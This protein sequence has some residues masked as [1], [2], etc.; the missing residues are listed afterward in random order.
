[1]KNLCKTC[2]VRE[3]C[4][5]AYGKTCE[6]SCESYRPGAIEVTPA[7]VLAVRAEFDAKLREVDSIMDRCNAL[8]LEV[9]RLT[10]PEPPTFMGFVRWILRGFK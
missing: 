1:M 8:A 10:I 6:T 9:A 7:N 3:F 2:F 4:E 5:F